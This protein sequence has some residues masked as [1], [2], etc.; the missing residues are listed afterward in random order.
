MGKRCPYCRQIIADDSLFCP[1]CG[2]EYPKGKTCSSCGAAI[3]DNDVYCQNCGIAVIKGKA[4]PHCGAAINDGDVFCQNCGEPVAQEKACPHCHGAIS[5]E[6]LYCPNCGVVVAI[7]KVCPH[8]GAAINDV[9]VFCQN[10]GEAVAKGKAC[11]HCHS[12]INEDDL[13]CQNC[14][15]KLNKGEKSPSSDDNGIIT[16]IRHDIPKV[17][18]ADSSIPIAPF[19]LPIES[20]YDEVKSDYSDDASTKKYGKWIVISLIAIALIGGGVYFFLNRSS[21]KWESQGEIIVNGSKTLHGTIGEFPVTMELNIEAS[22]VDGSMYYDKYGPSNKLFVSGSLHNN[23][24]ELKEHNND[25]METGRYKGKYSNGVF[26]G[27]YINYKGDVYS[28]YLSEAGAENNEKEDITKKLEEIF[29]DVVKGNARDCDERY[30]SSDFKRIYKEVE[31]IDNRF[32]QG[33][34]GF[35]DFGFW[36]MSQDCDG[37][38]I[39]VND[40]YGIKEKE[41]MA[42]VTFTVINYGGASESRNEDIKIIFEDGKW[43]LDDLHGYKKQMKDYIEEYKDAQ[44]PLDAGL[45]ME[46]ITVFFEELFNCKTAAIKEYGFTLDDKQSKM[47][48]TFYKGDDI[49]YEV[50]KEVYSL[51][52]RGVRITCVYVEG[53]Q[54]PS[55]TIECDAIT[56]NELEH[57]ADNSLRRDEDGD[58]CLN[59]GYVSFKSM[60][61][62]TMTTKNG[63]VSW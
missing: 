15:T 62:I 61:T 11:P 60:G 56:W 30:F 63:I 59:N 44:P 22:N 21:N 25:G 47:K 40:V 38:S 26:Q 48:S 41:A 32:Y 7:G 55:M 8:C 37:M 42:K 34:V 10:C 16:E 19:P 18:E 49:E 45:T 20:E 50:I 51:K 39:T 57:E 17:V 14:G 46:N 1:I 6:D 43:V 13:F 33:E 9:D 5:D 4:C 58:Y 23:E 35:W 36:D 12:A 31:D 3:S 24:I 54:E 52:N 29:D 27:E 53:W 28:F 2:K